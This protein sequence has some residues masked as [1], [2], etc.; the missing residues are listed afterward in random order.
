MEDQ[1][2]KVVVNIGNYDGKDP[3]EIIFR[4]GE[5]A[6]QPEPLATKPPVSIDI[7]G[8]ISTPLDWLEK[9]VGT[10]DQLKANIQV[11]R[12]KIILEV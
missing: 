8:V 5:A 3:I 9:R 2:E 11:N 12:E 4:N 7:E 6:T 10:I 1:K